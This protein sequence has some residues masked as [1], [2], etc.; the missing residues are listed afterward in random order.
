MSQK[1][2]QEIRI[3]IGSSSKPEALETSL[4]VQKAL[5][6][7]NDILNNYKIT[8]ILWTD[9]FDIGK[10]NL[11]TLFTELEND[12]AAIF[13]Y[14]GDD[15][16]IKGD[17]VEK[18]KVTRANVIFEHGLFAGRLG[19][20]KVFLL[21]TGGIK[22][23]DEKIRIKQTPSINMMLNDYS[24]MTV[25]YYN[26]IQYKLSGLVIEFKK[27]ITKSVIGRKR[28]DSFIGE[29]K[30]NNY[31]IT[32]SIVQTHGDNDNRNNEFIEM[33]KN[34][35]AGDSIKVLGSGVTSFLLG[36]YIEDLLGRGVNITVLLMHEKIIKNDGDCELEKRYKELLKKINRPK[37]RNNNLFSFDKS[38]PVSIKNV[39]IDKN[40]FEDYQKK[41]K[42]SVYLNNM[43]QAYENCKHFKLNFSDFFN[44]YYF[45]S[46]IPMSMTALQKK[47]KKGDGRLI[48]EFII[49]FTRNRI[50]LKVLEKEDE[51][52]FKTFMKFYDSM[53]EQ[54]KVNR[55]TSK[56]KSN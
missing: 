43:H 6:K 48:V 16:L 27:W 5:I 20:E 21:L 23:E 46:F 38:C 31:E 18:V 51:A 32:A 50:L 10:S 14:N 17:D 47:D 28:N 13:I 24:G 33:Y 15:D 11:E 45:Y 52:I 25:F 35:Q 9:V 30:K 44:Y 41:Q 3:F 53:E 36:N 39:L 34:A 7:V 37:I 55:K 54:S 26:S 49:P 19:K 56:E 29:N 1:E 4:E 2:K 42:N 40:H 8:P 22:E 12:N